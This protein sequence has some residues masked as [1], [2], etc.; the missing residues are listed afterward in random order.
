M[1]SSGM[2]RR[3]DLVWTDVSVECIT[4]IFRV[5]KSANEE[6]AWAGGCR[7]LSLRYIPPKRR[8]TQDLHGVTSQKTA[9][10]ILWLLP[11]RTH[12]NMGTPS[13]DSNWA[14]LPLKWKPRITVIWDRLIINGYHYN[15]KYFIPFWENE[16][17]QD[18]SVGLATGYGLDD[19]DVGVRVSVGSKIFTSPCRPDRLWGPPNLL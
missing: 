19:Q 16:W 9:F 14:G 6:P 1:P 10:F 7:L 15:C 5:E 4:S 18:S 3:V 12:E 11:G 17:S 8:L 2:W 13:L